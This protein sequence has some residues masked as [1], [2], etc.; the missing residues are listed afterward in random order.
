MPF[1]CCVPGDRCMWA[2][3]EQKKLRLLCLC[4]CCCCYLY[5]VNKHLLPVLA[6]VPKPGATVQT[7]ETTR[8]SARGLSQRSG[9]TID[10]KGGSETRQTCALTETLVFLTVRQAAVYSW[11]LIQA[12][13][14]FFLYEVLIMSFP[15][16]QKGH[17]P[18]RNV[19]FIPDGS[20]VLHTQHLLRWLKGI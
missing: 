11:V 19:Q 16:F 2:S 8:L 20:T 14:F 5:G 7:V 15:A 9:A 10:W 12:V 17:N 1:L 18:R 4:C 3:R 6:V 13:F